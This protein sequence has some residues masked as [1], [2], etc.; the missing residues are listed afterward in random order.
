[1]NDTNDQEQVLNFDTI[2]EALIQHVVDELSRRKLEIP[3]DLAGD[4]NFTIQL[5]TN[6][7]IEVELPSGTLQY[8]P[9]EFTNISYST[10]CRKGLFIVPAEQMEWTFQKKK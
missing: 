3:R 8:K 10:T 7:A 4:V 6:G 2:R 9:H 5:R 1:M